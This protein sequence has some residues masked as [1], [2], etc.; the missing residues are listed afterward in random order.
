MYLH[1]VGSPQ[2]PRGCETCA[3]LLHPAAAHTTHHHSG[4]HQH[5]VGTFIS[6]GSIVGCTLKLTCKAALQ[7][8]HACAGS[9]HLALLCTEPLLPGS[10]LSTG[11]TLEY[12]VSVYSAF[13]EV[14]CRG[15]M[16]CANGPS[17]SSN[18]S[19]LRYP[20]S[21]TRRQD[22]CCGASG[23]NPRAAAAAMLYKFDSSSGSHSGLPYGAMTA[24]ATASRSAM[25]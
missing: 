19:C 15:R 1:H 8:L 7:T 24:A 20:A 18:C 9:V 5:C 11:R 12:T 21:S 13:S 2:G 25:N 23:G 17:S 10:M 3:P 4:T 6:A 16:G 22:D 14:T